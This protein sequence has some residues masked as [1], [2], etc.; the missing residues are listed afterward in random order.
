MNRLGLFKRAAG[1]VATPALLTAPFWCGTQAHD[2]EYRNCTDCKHGDRGKPN[3]P[4]PNS[5]EH[6]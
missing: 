6:P 4:D 5:K 1:L 2:W 3:V